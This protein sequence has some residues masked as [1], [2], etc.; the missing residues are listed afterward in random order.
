MSDI[1]EPLTQSLGREPVN[2]LSTHLGLPGSRR[3]LLCLA[4]TPPTVQ[5]PPFAS[6]GMHDLARHIRRF[7]DKVIQCKLGLGWLT[8]ESEGGPARG[9]ENHRQTNLP[10]L[11]HAVGWQ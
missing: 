11:Q 3:S 10:V 7:S 6:L 8:R 1:K 4:T 2:R 5:I 9:C